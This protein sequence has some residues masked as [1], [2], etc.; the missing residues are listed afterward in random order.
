M[1]RLGTALLAGLAAAV[2]SFGVAAPAGAQS[3]GVTSLRGAKPIE[4]TGPPPQ[5]AVQDTETGP[6][7]RSYRQLPPMIPHD[8]E[9]LEI[10]LAGNECLTCHD[11]PNNVDTGA[12]RISESHYIDRGGI[13]RESVVGSRWFCTQC[14]APQDEVEAL[15]PNT[16]KPAQDVR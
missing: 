11:W 4:E 16:F 3:S 13:A 12:T 7:G 14:H 2:V 6:F 15:V 10:G 1:S 5:M 8:I 9:G